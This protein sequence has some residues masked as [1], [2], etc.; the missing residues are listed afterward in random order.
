MSKAKKP[1]TGR[2]VIGG[3]VAFFLVVIGVNTLMSVL[4]IRT[5]SG[6]ETSDAYRKGRDFNQQI[7]EDR[8]EKSLGW[9]VAVTTASSGKGDVAGPYSVTVEVTDAEGARVDQ[10]S[11]TGLLFRP[12]VK[13]IDQQVTFTAM[14]DGTYQ[15]EAAL[16]AQGRWQLQAVIQSDDGRTRQ[17]V[18]DL[19]FAP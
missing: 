12:V 11:I 17:I 8:A 19:F 15:A 1:L 14:P 16:P 2:T 10:L 6:V 3:F 13:G 18:Q 7:A 4:A 5:F 9:H